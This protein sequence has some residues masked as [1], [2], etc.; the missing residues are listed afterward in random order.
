MVSGS[1][2]SVG[3][4]IAMTQPSG[5][6]A[7]IYG[8]YEQKSIKGRVE[9]FFLDNLGKIATREQIIAVSKDPNTGA[10]PENWHQRLS[11]LRTD[12]GYTILSRRDRSDL[13]SQEY[14]M[15]DAEKRETAGP[16][17]R[18]KPEVWQQTLAAHGNRCAWAEG[19]DVCGLRDGDIDPVGG[20]TVKLTPDHLRPHSIEPAI[21]PDDP[22]KWQ[23]LCGRHQVTKRNFWDDET[24]WLNVVAIV[25]AASAQQKQV[26]FDFLKDF[27]EPNTE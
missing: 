10:E 21:D 9:A 19:N 11:E 16:R 14:M 20:G 24:G 18:P 13:K 22:L 25:Q 4:L 3:E 8:P 17:V 12:D 27:F 5:R 7:V 23:P 2:Y 6:Y 26:V 1:D 15:P